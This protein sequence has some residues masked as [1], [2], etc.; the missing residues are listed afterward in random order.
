MNDYT[1]SDAEIQAWA[2]RL[3]ARGQITDRAFF[4]LLHFAQGLEVYR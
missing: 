2:Y 3:R 4:I 1:P